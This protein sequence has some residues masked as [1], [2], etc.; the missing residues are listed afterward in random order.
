M[1]ADAQLLLLDKDTVESALQTQ[2]V[3]GAVREAFELHSERAGRVFPVIREKL[4]TGG[5]FGIKAGDVA[6]Q[7]LLGFKAAGFWPGNRQSNGEPHQATI[8][9]IDPATGRPKAILDGNA[10]TTMRTGAAGAIGLKALARPDSRRVCLFGTGVQ[11]RIQLWY[12]LRTLP[13]LKEVQYVSLSGEAD[14]SFEAAFDGSCMIRV[15]K[16]KNEAVS[17]SDV[18]ITATPGGGALFDA[19]ALQAGS[20][21]TCVGADT[22]GKRELPSGVLERARVYV[23][24]AIQARSIGECQ[25]LAGVESTEIGD[26]LVGKATL[27]RNHSDITLF[28]MTGLALQDL[29]VARLLYQHALSENKGKMIAWAW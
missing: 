21:L 20:H 1:P 22:A 17:S 13:T 3:L 4:H 7:D 2:D 26:L 24:D 5:V 10:I 29:T 12:A 9:L 6:A 19:D 23:D 14:A 18:I 25:W 27:H 8:V 28:D 16:D 15:A 11:A